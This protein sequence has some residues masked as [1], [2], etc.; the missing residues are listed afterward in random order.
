MRIQ[1]NLKTDFRELFTVRKDAH[2]RQGLTALV[3][4]MAFSL[5]PSGL[6]GLLMA[7]RY[8]SAL[9]DWSLVL[10]WWSPDLLMLTPKMSSWKRL[11]SCERRC[12]GRHKQRLTKGLGT[13]ALL[14][15]SGHE[16]HSGHC[17]LLY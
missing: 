2:L 1:A 6:A 15:G 5:N 7:L 10:S 14:K 9:M 17:D 16:I 3:M 8:S 11:V 12:Q 13:W 4:G